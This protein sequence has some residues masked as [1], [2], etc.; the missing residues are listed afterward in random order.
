MSLGLREDDGQNMTDPST[1]SFVTP[2][3][4]TSNLSTDSDPSQDPSLTDSFVPGS[5]FRRREGA[6][7]EKAAKLE[8][9]KANVV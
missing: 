7:H 4:T 2:Y 5:A 1:P 8:P 3:Y 6:K 9:T